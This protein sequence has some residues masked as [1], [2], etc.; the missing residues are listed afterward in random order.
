MLPLIALEVYLVGDNIVNVKAESL[1]CSY[2][3]FTKCS[4][5]GCLTMSGL[6]RGGEGKGEIS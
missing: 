1:C 3:I 4:M 2:V 5:I 6:N